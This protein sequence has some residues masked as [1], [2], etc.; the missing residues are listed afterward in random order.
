[1][2]TVL[3]IGAT[4]NIGT[5]AVKGALN[6]GLQVLAVV[7][8]SASAEK[9]FQNLGTKEG[10][11][12]VEADILSDDGVQS[13]V[14]QVKEGKLP[15]F[16]HVYATAGGAYA[17][18]DLRNITTEELRHLMRVNFEPNFFAYRATIPY[19]L[20]QN[21]GNSS[22]TLCTGS[23]GEEGVRAGPGMTQGALFS[24]AVAACRELHG[25]NIR[26]NEVLLC[27]RVEVDQD[28]EKSGAMKA[29]DFAKNY[30]TILGQPDVRGS[31][32]RVE[33]YDD[34]MKLSYEPKLNL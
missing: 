26:F 28:A 23:Q 2:E 17:L 32:I 11:K 3:I 31:R 10:I 29:S 20:E 12:T 15:T 24:M 25:T 34:L 1:M 18:T 9:L 19:L 22:W 27:R 5:A 4:G 16:Q 14:D 30:E 6:A 13:V 7:R 33:T 21:S 8:N